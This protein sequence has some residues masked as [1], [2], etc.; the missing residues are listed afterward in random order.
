[1]LARG[2]ESGSYGKGTA[3]RALFSPTMKG[4]QDSSGDRAKKR[5][6][7]FYPGDEE[8]SKKRGRRKIDLR[9]RMTR[10]GEELGRPKSKKSG[11]IGKTSR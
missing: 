5:D 3:S 8:R 9:L 2:P 4:V 7:A 11:G 10:R 1:M 6:V